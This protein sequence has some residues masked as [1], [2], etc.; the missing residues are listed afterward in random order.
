MC[1][2]IK[3]RYIKLVSRA[4][5]GF[6]MFVYQ[7]IVDCVIP[8]KGVCVCVG[9][10]H[11]VLS[12]GFKDGCTPLVLLMLYGRA[13]K[14]CVTVNRLFHSRCQRNVFLCYL[15]KQFY[16]QNMFLLV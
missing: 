5:F 13:V 1:V 6:L 10:I 7:Q 3:Y 4:A 12:C 14:H 16:L 8:R 11:V 15:S 9:G 2:C